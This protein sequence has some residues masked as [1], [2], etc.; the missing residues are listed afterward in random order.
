MMKTRLMWVL[1]G[2]TTVIAGLVVQGAMTAPQPQIGFT[3]ELTI[4]LDVASLDR[5][6]QFYTTRLGF[7]LTERRDDLK[8]AHIQTSVPGV[9]LGLGEVADPKPNQAILNFSV[10]DADLAR[11]N[12]EAAGV[13]FTGATLE[14]PGKVKLAGFLDPD[15]NRLRLAGPSKAR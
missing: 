1:G 15:G 8:F 4:Q 14:I 11:K 7:K 12:L 10:K 9:D 5:S 13:V 3:P 2:I 6:I